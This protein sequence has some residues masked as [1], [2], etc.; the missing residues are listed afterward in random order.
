MFIFPIFKNK[1]L[2]L[3]SFIIFA[4]GAYAQ[5]KEK[6]A[7]LFNNG[8]DTFDKNDFKTAD[9]LFTLSI[10]LDPNPD[11]YFN[12]AVC[13]KKLNDFTGYCIDLGSAT[14]LG[15]KTASGVFWKECA[16][17][18]S[19]YRKDGEV[20]TSDSYFDTAEFIYTFAYNN[21]M[22]Y[23]KYSNTGKLLTSYIKLGTDTT[24]RKCANVADPQY[25]K[26]LPEFG[27]YILQNTK[28]GKIVKK[29][30]YRGSMSLAL[31]INE[32][33]KL[34]DV[35]VLIG[36]NNG[37]A[38]T[39]A[40]EL[41]NSP[42]WQPPLYNGRYVKYQSTFNIYFSGNSISVYPVLPAIKSLQTRVSQLCD[43]TKIKIEPESNAEVF[44]LVES[45]PEFPGGIAEMMKY[46][47]QNI[48]YPVKE[49]DKGIQGK[50]WLKFVVT[51][52]GSICD[53]VVLKGVPNCD[54]CDQE[55]IRVIQS[56]PK[57]KPGSQNGHNVAVFF[58]LPINFQLSVVRERR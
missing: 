13:R 27:N 52:N 9:S 21:N 46:I 15:D 48:T 55:A 29:K 25:Q 11:T 7:E 42:S 19:I 38:D 43:T 22:Q 54:A 1:F 31:T 56:M 20:V 39:L 30:N 2:L 57:W 50:C 51:P 28:F 4:S 3:F 40:K 49:R 14:A 35:Q 58:N 37:L 47:Q 26:G 6:A 45:M 36:L 44:T 32:V 41:L 8:V 33:G 17:G 12:R 18:D 24:Y 53:V 5:K 10:A 23:D 16:K 34:N